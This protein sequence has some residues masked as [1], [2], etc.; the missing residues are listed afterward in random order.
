MSRIVLLLLVTLGLGA[1]SAVGQ[2]MDPATKELIDRLLAR[3]D[4][5]EKRVAELEGA[6]AA[7]KPVVPATQAIHEAH[8]QPPVPQAAVAEAAPVYPSLKISGFGD[9]DFSATDLHSAATGFGAQTLLSP[10]SGFEEGQFTLHLSSALSPKVTMFGELTLTA[11]ADAGTGTPPAPG[12][13]AE[14][15]RVII[16]YDVNDYFK[17]SF[18]RYH[19]PINY[20][21]TAFHHGQ[22]LQTTIS[23]PEMTQFGGSFIP[24][25]FVGSLA[26]GAI[27]AGG[28]NLN[29]AAGMGNG[30]GQVIS[31]GGDFADINNNRAWLVNAFREAGCVV[32]AAGGRFGV[33]RRAEPADGAGGA[34]VDRIGSRG[35]AQG[36]A[37]VYRGI[38]QRGAPAHRRRNGIQQPGVLRTNSVP[39]AVAAEGCGS[40]ITAS[41]IFM[42]RNRT[43]FSGRWCRPSTPPRSECGMTSPRLRR[44]SSNSAS[45]CAAICPL[46]T[47][48][49][50]RRVSHFRPAHEEL[51]H[52]ETGDAA[53]A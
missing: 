1:P 32:R 40:R 43:R 15:E 42:C 52:L 44:S 29:Y 50:G 16:R 36:D 27:P 26:E 19:T 2:T 51:D 35:L 21:N 25:H 20:W 6:K 8:E 13:N 30:R 39:A 48:S 46:S 53:G 9:I 10:H 45:T 18:G 5:L 12:F 24:V 17:L 11:R 28:L 31:R 23:R 49:S 7:A 3:I 38:R 33:S 34:G 41:N 14:V 37:G 4:G 47:G 22:W